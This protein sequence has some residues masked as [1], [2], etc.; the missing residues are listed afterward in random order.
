MKQDSPCPVD[1]DSWL[2]PEELW[3]GKVG[4]AAS[5]TDRATV[6]AVFDPL[7]CPTERR[8]PVLQVGGHGVVDALLLVA[9]PDKSHRVWP[10]DHLSGHCR[11]RPAAAAPPHAPCL[12]A[13][14]PAPV[15]RAAAPLLLLLYMPREIKQAR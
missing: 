3:L 4:A 10:H 9:A 6:A 13:I 1:C 15:H 12:I 5:K 11:F 14:E 8:E 7:E 2:K